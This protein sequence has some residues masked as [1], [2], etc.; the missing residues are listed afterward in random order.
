MTWSSPV[1]LRQPADLTLEVLDEIAWEDRPL[2]LHSDLLARLAASRAA[3]VAA[4]EGGGS[5]YGVNTGMGYVAGVRLSEEEQR[6][7]QANLL[8]GRAVGGPPYLDYAEA[9]AVLV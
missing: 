3:V 7:H 8:L 2:A 1:V 4:L 6:A 9:R 5:V